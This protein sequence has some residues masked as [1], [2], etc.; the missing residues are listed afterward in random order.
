V[1]FAAPAGFAEGLG[2]PGAQRRAVEVLPEVRV[3]HPVLEVAV[4]GADRAVEPRRHEDAE[5]GDVA[6]VDVHEAENLGLRESEGVKH[7]AR[8]QLRVGGQIDDHLHADGPL[9]GVV[10]L[11]HAEL[12]VELLA[13]R[14]DR[15]VADHGQRGADVHARRKRAGG[16]AVFLDALIDEAHADDL[17]VLDERGGRRRGGPDLHGAG[18]HRL[19]AD[20]L[21][22]LAHGE[23]ESVVF[24]EEGRNP[25][26][27]DRV[28]FALK[29]FQHG[30]G[31]AQRER[32]AAGADGIE[33]VRDFFRLHR[34]G[35][36]DLRGIKLRET[37]L[38]AARRGD[39][40]RDAEA[41]V[42]GPL[43]AD[44]LRRHAR[45]RLAL[46][47]GR[48][49]LLEEVF[50][51]RGEKAARRGAEADADDVNVHART[52][53]GGNG[54]GGGVLYHGGHGGH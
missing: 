16:R 19:R 14:T 28:V 35:H 10:P 49:V 40:A 34:R 11:G 3:H 51:E 33:Q 25:R 18:A 15:A 24:R 13:E 36:R 9:V 32:A 43:V 44:H 6:R 38:D 21:H 48:A 42:V 53:D 46:D 37:G 47:G 1:R 12:A 23:H 2:A 31:R 5:R 17:L 20:P 8:L 52:L 27:L 26:Q 54:F 22:E 29:K 7:R 39:D 50:R 45:H 41:H 4:G 30:V